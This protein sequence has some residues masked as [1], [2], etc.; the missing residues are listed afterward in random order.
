VLSEYPSARTFTV[1]SSFKYDHP[2]DEVRDA[3]SAIRAHVPSIP[4]LIDEERG[5]SIIDRYSRRY[6]EQITALAPVVNEVARFVPNRRKRKLHIG[7]F[8]YAREME[9]ITLPRAIKFTAALYSVGLPPE[10]L[11]LDALT[12]DDIAAVKTFYRSFTQDISDALRYANLGS[13]F[14]PEGVFEAAGRIAGGTTPD[15]ETTELTSRIER[16][17]IERRT[18]TATELVLQAAHRR[19]FLG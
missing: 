8:G 7:L 1:Q 5:L 6:R 4:P 10:L 2:P 11:G 16:A 18:E 9:G 15:T 19:R 13:S 3:V 14:A 17:V 12:D